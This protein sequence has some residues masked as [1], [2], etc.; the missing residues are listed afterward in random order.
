M[1]AS[2]PPKTLQLTIKE[3]WLVESITNLGSGFCTHLAYSIQ[4]IEPDL[5]R[6]IQGPGIQGVLGEILKLDNTSIRCMAGVEVVKTHDF[7]SFIRFDL[8]LLEISPFIKALSV[9]ITTKY[10]CYYQSSNR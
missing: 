4:D 5:L 7:Q 3:A 2:H 6:D 10:L 8:R 1:M 9:G